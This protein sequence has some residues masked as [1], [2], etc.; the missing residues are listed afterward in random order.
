MK[1][2]LCAGP[3]GRFVRDTASTD[4]HGTIYVASHNKS[5]DY[6]ALHIKSLTIGIS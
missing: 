4:R 1:F 3:Q 5:S 2:A 6:F